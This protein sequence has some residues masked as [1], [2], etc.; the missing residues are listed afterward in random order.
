[1]SEL[2]HFGDPH[3]RPQLRLLASRDGQVRVG[4][5]GLGQLDVQRERLDMGERL[6][7]EARLGGGGGK[8]ARANECTL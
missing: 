3:E 6:G 5:L 2:V 1:V 7:G 4:Q 8:G